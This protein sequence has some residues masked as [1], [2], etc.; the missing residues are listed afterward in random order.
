MIDLVPVAL[1]SLSWLLFRSCCLFDVAGASLSFVLVPVVFGPL[2]LDTSA[3]SSYLRLDRL[4]G[5]VL[6]YFGFC[7]LDFYATLEGVTNNSHPSVWPFNLILLAL[8]FL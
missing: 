7:T 1:I 8:S 5:I 3:V 4:D 2:A 6:G